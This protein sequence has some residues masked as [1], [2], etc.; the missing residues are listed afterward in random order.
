MELKWTS[1]GL[2]KPAPLLTEF[3]AKQDADEDTRK[4]IN[5]A[6]RVRL[7]MDLITALGPMQPD[8]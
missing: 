8:S 7:S 1:T 6:E 5:Q 3:S 2:S 4:H